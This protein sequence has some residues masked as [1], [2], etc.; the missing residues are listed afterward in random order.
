MGMPIRDS[1]G[2][3]LIRRELAIELNTGQYL[4]R[5][6]LCEVESCRCNTYIPVGFLPAVTLLNPSPDA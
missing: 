6:D 1:S 4:V 3:G 2:R 5:N